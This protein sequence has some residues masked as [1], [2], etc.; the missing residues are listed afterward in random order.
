MYGAIFSTGKAK[1]TNDCE[2]E[3]VVVDLA[4]NLFDGDRKVTS[5]FSKIRSILMDSS[6]LLLDIDVPVFPRAWSTRGTASLDLPSGCET[7]VDNPLELVNY[8]FDREMYLLPGK[9]HEEGSPFIVSEVARSFAEDT[10][11][12]AF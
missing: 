9:I 4:T 7:F 3:P 8:D 11:T 1:A 12:I 6:R 10:E 2:L 5:N